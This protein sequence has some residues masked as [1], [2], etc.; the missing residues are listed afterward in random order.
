MENLGKIASGSLKAAE[1]LVNY[2]KELN[3]GL[4]D[5]NERDYDTRLKNARKYLKGSST[6]DIHMSLAV[7]NGIIDEIGV[8]KEM[9]TLLKMSEEI[10]KDIEKLKQIGVKPQIYSGYANKILENIGKKL[11]E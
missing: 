5:Y 2:A 7:S 10:G 11:K 9:D 8:L 1:T 6:E 3:N 4:F